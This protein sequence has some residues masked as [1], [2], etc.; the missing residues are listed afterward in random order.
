M[1]SSFQVSLI[2]VTGSPFILTIFGLVY[3][4]NI[5]FE[6]ET[7]ESQICFKERTSVL[8]WTTALMLLDLSPLI[9]ASLDS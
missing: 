7:K 5:S 4:E 2:L 6:F 8:H 1:E 3:F 9:K